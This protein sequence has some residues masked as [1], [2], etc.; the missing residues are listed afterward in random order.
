MPLLWPGQS[1]P[2]LDYISSPPPV[3]QQWKIGLV[4][5]GSTGSVGKNT[6][7]IVDKHPDRFQILGLAGGKNVNLLAKQALHYRPPFLAVLDE[8]QAENLRRLLPVDYRVKIFTSASGYAAMAALAE[9]DII[10]SAQVGAAGLP[11][12]LS[13]A[14][15]GKTIALANKESLVL[16]GNLLKAICQETGA[17]ILPLDSEH[18]ALF[19]CLVGREQAVSRLVL[20]ASGGPFRNFSIQELKAVKAEQALKGA[21]W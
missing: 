13:A 11:A 9:A 19:Q 4:I 1:G 7:S 3:R 17:S 20:T 18:F 8:E 5:M 21:G 10:V 15:A 12:T 16:A 2:A 6:L 14:F